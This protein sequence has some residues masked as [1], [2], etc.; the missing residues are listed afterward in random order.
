MKKTLALVILIS[1]ICNFHSLAQQRKDVAHSVLSKGDWYKISIPSN[2]VYKLTYNDFISLGIPD[3][4]I[5]SQ[6]LSIFGN[7]GH[8]IPTNN[9]LSPQTDLQENSI[10]VFDPNN[11]LSK[12]GYVLFYGESSTQYSYNKDTRAWSATIHPYSDNAY[13]FITF[14]DSIGQKLRIDSVSY[15]SLSADSTTNLTRDFFFYKQ[16]LNNVSASGR[17]WVGKQ[18]TLDKEEDYPLD[19]KNAYVDSNYNF[20]RPANLT[21]QLV[22]KS[23]ATSTFDINY[24]SAISTTVT[25]AVSSSIT[26]AQTSDKI[27]S[28]TLPSAKIIDNKLKITFHGNSVAQGWLDYIMISYDKV[29]NYNYPSQLHYRT[30]EHLASNLNVRNVISN[31]SANNIFVWDISNYTNP[32]KIIGSYNSSEK[33]YS[34]NLNSS[35]LKDIIV[36]QPTSSFYSVKLIGKIDNQDLHSTPA[37]DYVI[38]TPPEFLEQAERLGELHEQYNNTST[39]VVT[40]QQVYNEF[41]SGNPDF[42]AYKEYLRYLYNE[43]KDSNKQPKNVLLFGKGTFDNK[44][45]LA[46]NNN[47]ILTYQADNSLSSQYTYPCEDYVAYLSPW[48][49]GYSSISQRDTMLVGVG[50]LPITSLEQAKIL[51][52]KSERYMKRQDIRD[53]NAINNWRNTMVITCDDSDDGV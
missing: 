53:K 49:K 5:K 32:T 24:N 40:T 12:G 39:K 43:Y 29:L 9:S 1:F 14:N 11:D 47:F 48:A 21:C 33:T 34:Y 6:N 2:G 28:T 7:G 41:S 27:Y 42:L 4:A 26:E 8:Q 18:F 10:Y 46:Y 20:I 44:N 31:V 16:E 36:F 51:V 52:D 23:T 25:N 17:R 30:T 3:S 35:T 22:S 45:I 13:Y 15:E 50:R 37:V 19:L 38:I